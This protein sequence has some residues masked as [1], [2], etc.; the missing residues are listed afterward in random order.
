MRKALLGTL[1][2]ATLLVANATFAQGPNAGPVWKMIY[3]RIRPGQDS[4][5]WK[6]YGENAKPIQQPGPDAASRRRES[7]YQSYLEIDSLVTGAN[8]APHWR[9]DGSSFW[10]SEGGPGETVIYKVDPVS[11]TRTE[12]FD[13]LRLRRALEQTL[14]HKLPAQGVPFQQFSELP[15]ERVRFDLAGMKFELDLQTYVAKKLPPPDP[16]GLY[17]GIT[18]Q[19]RFTPRTFL[20]EIYVAGHSPVP[21]VLSP[22]RNLFA[23]IQNHNV[24]LR[25]TSDNHITQFTTDGV[26]DFDW[27]LESRQSKS[28][29]PWSPNSLYLFAATMDR[30]DVP[31]IPI[32]QYVKTSPDLYWVRFPYAGG[33]IDR[34]QPYILD[35]LGRKTVKLDLGETKDQYIL[36]LGWLPDGSEVLL[37]R[38]ARDFRRVD[39][40]GAEPATGKTRLI[41]TE[42]GP[43]FVRSPFE[44]LFPGRAEFTLLPDGKSFIWESERDGWNHLYL[45]DLQGKLIRRLT[46]GQFPVLDVQAVDQQSGF[47]YFTAHAEPRL[48]DTHLYRVPLQGGTMQKLT[49]A[50]GQHQIQFAPS[51]R[52]FVDRHSSP[53]RPPTI[54]LRTSDGR[55]L[56]TMGQADISRL[57]QVGWT[58]P[59][60]FV[61]KADDGKTPLWGVL[62][63]PFDFDSRKRYP[64]VEYIYGGP[65]IVLVNHGF[66]AGTGAFSNFPQ[67]LAQLG[68]IV[69]VL[70]GRATPERSKAFQDTNSANWLG[71]LIPDHAGAIR[72]LG[73]KNS[74]MDMNRVGIFGHSWGATSAFRALTDA[75]DLYKAAVASSPGLDAY[76]GLLYEAYLGL[77][78][79]NKSAYD[80]AMAYPLASKVKG[81]LLLVCG[82]GESIIMSETLRLVH[83]FME[84]GIKH[85]LIV[86]PGQFHGYSDK[87]MDYYMNATRDFLSRYLA[88]GS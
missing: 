69:V 56:R 32:V 26:A 53:A 39:I 35:I 40:I 81:R 44:V 1:I 37:A 51:R 88:P 55:L 67:A 70:D 16:S 34:V 3:Y 23:L 57:R 63:K 84:L 80:A 58:P 9:S 45:Y 6:D 25:T 61:V 42:Q 30:R 4:A 31:K 52:F 5:F 36:L 43:T 28:A 87:G 62:Y 86:L 11:N 77:P 41:L 60:E 46:E 8:L 2:V 22:D 79:Q 83:Q 15:G 21:E 49:E 68:F 73:A 75:P 78:A 20:R 12:Y 18:E 71:S 82:T 38:F 10:Y 17:Y 85:E 66:A 19:Q 29:S 74:Y 27:D 50:E 13:A 65:Q 48:Y 47:V 14:G 24:C 64:V 7:V 54:E 76:G 72:Q 59:E 33:P